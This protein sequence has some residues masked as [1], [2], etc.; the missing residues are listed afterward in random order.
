MSADS[1]AEQPVTVVATWN[2]HLW[3]RRRGHVEEFDLTPMVEG[4]A[5]NGYLTLATPDGDP[6][7]VARVKPKPHGAVTLPSARPVPKPRPPR[8]RLVTGK[9]GG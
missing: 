1:N 8:R 9:G 5:A 4:A 7:A 3:G 6:V 2:V